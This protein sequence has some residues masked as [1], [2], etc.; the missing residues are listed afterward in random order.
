MQEIHTRLLSILARLQAS[1]DRFQRGLARWLEQAHE[2]ASDNDG[3]TVR[4]TATSGRETWYARGAIEKVL[5]EY[6]A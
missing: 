1:P 3:A 2:V 4:I 6:G 5:R